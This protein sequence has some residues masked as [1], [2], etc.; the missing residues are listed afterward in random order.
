MFEASAR[1]RPTWANANAIDRI[2]SY[3]SLETSGFAVGDQNHFRDLAASG[4]KETEVFE[5]GDH[6]ALYTVV[7]LKTDDGSDDEVGLATSAAPLT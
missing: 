2:F 5:D 4:D 6:G 1:F 7:G 3:L